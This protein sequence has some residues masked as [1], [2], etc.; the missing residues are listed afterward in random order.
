MSKISS[1]GAAYR[2]LNHSKWGEGEDL[3]FPEGIDTVTVQLTGSPEFEE[4]GSNLRLTHKLK[5]FPDGPSNGGLAKQVTFGPNQTRGIIDMMARVKD[6]NTELF[7]LS[8]RDGEF[9]LTLVPKIP[10]PKEDFWGEWFHGDDIDIDQIMKKMRGVW[11]YTGPWFEA[12][13]WKPAGR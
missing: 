12:R 2:H 4:V 1:W 8:L 10:N 9:T 6:P 3:R 5:V 7:R 13:R 11:K